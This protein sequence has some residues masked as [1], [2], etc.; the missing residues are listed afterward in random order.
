[1]IRKM[2]I[3]AAAVAIPVS[4]VGATAGTAS[5][6]GTPPVNATNYT[7][8]CT[9]IKATASFSPALTTNGGTASNEATKIKGTATNCTATPTSGGTPVTITNAKISGTINDATSTHTCSG[10]ASPTTETGSLKITWKTSP[11]LTSSVA[12][13]NPTTVTGG[14]GADG[15]A[16]FSLSFGPA[17]SG[18]FQGT[19]NGTSSSTNAET[20]TTISSILTTC[21]GKS[22]LKK[23]SIQPNANG[24]GPAVVA[25]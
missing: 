2:L 6:K 7:A 10:L 12:V 25:S 18:P 22:G 9:G 15:H 20:T 14:I 16:T 21:G 8:S 17:T 24:G 4:V 3:L 19:D 1:M 11:K 23:I 5:A 13:V